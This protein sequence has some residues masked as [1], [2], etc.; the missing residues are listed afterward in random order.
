MLSVP[1]CCGTHAQERVGLRCALGEPVSRE[2]TAWMPQ[3]AMMSQHL[4]SEQE[5]AFGVVGSNKRFGDVINLEVTE[6][7]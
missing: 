3:L 1:C 4:V 5:D 2:N 7:Q 6:D